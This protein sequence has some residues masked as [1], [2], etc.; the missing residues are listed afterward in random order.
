MG[1]EKRRTIIYS[2]LL[3]ILLIFGVVL[4]TFSGSISARVMSIGGE[5]PFA[6][7]IFGMIT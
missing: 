2:Y 7:L 3:I 5:K 4:N 6:V 1:V